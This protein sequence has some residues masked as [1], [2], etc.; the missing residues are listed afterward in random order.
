LIREKKCLCFCPRIS[1]V[2]LPSQEIKPFPGFMGHLKTSSTTSDDSN[3]ITSAFA[4]WKVVLG[5]R[6]TRD[7]ALKEFGCL[8]LQTNTRVK[9]INHSYL[10]L[11]E[12]NLKCWKLLLRYSPSSR[13]DRQ[14]REN[15]ARE[16]L[17]EAPFLCLS[18][19]TVYRRYESK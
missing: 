11:T 1:S 18:C 3:L 17:E 13:K 15:R 7:I 8:S 5:S 2:T 14:L 16:R 6:E 10:A 19:I 9:F 4:S 12:V